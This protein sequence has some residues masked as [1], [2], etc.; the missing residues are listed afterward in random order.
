MKSM[1]FR[2]L[3]GTMNSEEGVLRSQLLD[4]FGLMVTV[5]TESDRADRLRILQTVLTFEL[6][7]DRDP[8]EKSSEFLNALNKGGV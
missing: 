3:C 8:A 4:R 1:M 5:K 6:E 7:S 2:L